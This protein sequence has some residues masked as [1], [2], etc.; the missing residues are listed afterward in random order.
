MCWDGGEGGWGGGDG[1][2]T[3]GSSSSLSPEIRT[4]EGVL[5][6]V[7]DSTCWLPCIWGDA[8]PALPRLDPEVEAG[9]A[10]GSLS[11]SRRALCWGLVLAVSRT[12][13]VR[14]EAALAAVTLW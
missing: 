3:I 7:V 1:E 5:V 14:S 8:G 10:R 6:G 9:R 2:V 11:L 4:G 12:W 13:Q